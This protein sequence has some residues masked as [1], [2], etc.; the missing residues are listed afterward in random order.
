[1][2]EE[3]KYLGPEATEQLIQNAKSTVTSKVADHNT[4]ADAHSDIRDALANTV[5]FTEQT[6]TDEQKAQV[7]TNIGASTPIIDVNA[8]PTEN[9]DE[10]TF[11]RLMTD[12]L[13]F[14]QIIQTAYTVYRVDELP[15]IGEPAT[16]IDNTQGTVY[17]NTQDGS[18]N[19]YVDAILAA[20]LSIPAG[21]YPA[22][23]LLQA[24]G[25][26]YAGVI[27]DI[28][29]DP[30]DDA[31]RLLL[32]CEIYSY[33]DGWT[34]HKTIG[35]AGDGIKAEV[36]NY[37]YNKATGDYSHAEGYETNAKQDYSHAEGWASKAEGYGSHAEGYG[38]HAEGS[39]SHAEG[40][41]SHAEG[42]NTYAFGDYSHAEGRSITY[43]VSITGEQNATTYKCP[44]QSW[45][46]EGCLISRMING[47]DY[48]SSISARVIATDKLRNTIT[49]DRTLSADAPITNASITVHIGALAL[50]DQSHSEGRETIAA[51]RSQHTQGE[52]NTIDPEYDVND[53]TK[54][55]KYAHIVGNG[56]SHENRSNAHT[57]D[58]NG[59]GW[60]AGG[61]KV[62]GTGQ[63]DENAQE[64]AL[65]SDLINLSGGAQSDWNASEGEV[66]HI[67]NRTH[68]VES[69]VAILEETTLQNEDGD[70][71][72]MLEGDITLEVDK[73]YTIVYNGTEY[74]CTTIDGAALD[75]EMVGWVVFGNFSAAMGTGDTGEPFVG[76]NVPGYG[77]QIM[78]LS[79]ASTCTIAIYGDIIHKLDP[80][81]Y[82]RLA[83]VESGAVILEETTLQN[84]DGDSQFMLEGDITLE[85]G[86]TYR[87]VYN[88]TEYMCTAV[89]VATLD[90]EEPYGQQI[91]FGNYGVMAGMG[92]TGEPF[93]GINTPGMGLMVAD[94]SSASSCTIAIYEDTIHKIDNKF[95]DAEWMATKEMSAGTPILEEDSY[96]VTGTGA[97]TAYGAGLPEFTLE[98]DKEYVVLF[99]GIEYKR[100]CMCITQGDMQAFYLGNMSFGNS[101]YG[102]TGEPFLIFLFPAL[103]QRALMADVEGTHTMGLYECEMGYRKLP[104]EFL[105]K[106]PLDR[107]PKTVLTEADRTHW[108][109]ADGTVHQLD[110]K[111]IPAKWLADLHG[112]MVPFIT[113]G[114]ATSSPSKQVNITATF[115]MEHFDWG[116]DSDEGAPVEVIYDGVVYNTTMH[117]AGSNWYTGNLALASSSLGEDTGEPFCLRLS[118]MGAKLCT[119]DTVATAH[120]I[121]ASK[122]SYVP[123]PMPEEYLPDTVSL[124]SHTHPE[125]FNAN[126]GGSI[127]GDTNV[128]GVLR[129]QGQ[130]AFYYNTEA[131]TQTIGTN[132]ATGGTNIGCNANASVTINGASTKVPTVLPRANNSFTCGSS[133]FRWSGIYSTAA[134]NVSSD[135][136]LKRDIVPV[137]ADPIID[138][139]KNLNVV[140]YNYK[141]DAA[142]A[143]ARIGLIAQ[144]VQQAD[145]E[146]ADFFVSE[147]DNGMLGLKAADLVFPL[148]MMVQRLSAEV[149]ELKS[150]M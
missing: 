101:D 110:K 126:T 12:S 97:G 137:E 143:K 49:V 38:S 20:G 147:D 59:L 116:S 144:Q 96:S 89:D 90:P 29:D 64:V 148:I 26:S 78:D 100:T 27:T 65:K 91:L 79:G 48:T 3:I 134:V 111:Y 121:S 140:Q 122:L 83:W 103:S 44:A 109:D 85:D 62:G 7:R 52:Y 112:V 58:W 93:I 39:Y 35:L 141:D 36:F 30:C 108:T 4:A 15:E 125:Y 6:L 25:Y 72:F 47:E 115:N 73:T 24:L 95:I 136:R 18:L 132:N 54:R 10:N 99:D 22:A 128:N 114:T 41:A 87:I 80:K 135:E 92:D 63:D 37:P 8:L 74:T 142:D 51:G 129:V 130:Q 56:T 19:G 50:G 55:S 75:P 124:T 61:L 77:L 2:A 32:N 139:I 46:Y 133:D 150:K 34:S 88:G 45:V 105:P 94:L 53:N 82:E 123:N 138:F 17:Y 106:I 33:K 21:W 86:K 113:D 14:N 42:S 67:K 98:S 71:Q 57:I 69:G 118:S 84:E 81:F 149:E 146:V 1:M 66:G 43:S 16:N 13:V 31:F 9:I 60:F 127:G 119:T 68:W 145:P 23:V 76:I 131:N 28:L 70:S 40:Y 104:A 102:N 107:L 120:T 5:R 117:C 11:Y